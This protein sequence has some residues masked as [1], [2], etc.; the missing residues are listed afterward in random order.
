[1]YGFNPLD[2]SVATQDPDDDGL[3]N[4]QEYQS[5]GNPRQP[6][7]VAWGDN[8]TQES[9]VPWGFPAVPA[10]AAG[11]G[12]AAGGHTVLLMPD[13][14]VTAWGANTY[15]QT[16]VPLG[17]SN[18]VAVAAGGDQS[19]ALQ[20]NG[21]VVQWGRT[22]AAVPNYLS[23]VTAIAVGYQHKLAL[24]A[25]GTVVSW[26][27][28][29]CPANTV[30]GGLSN[31]VA[32]SAGWNHNLALRSDGTVVA[33]G[34][35]GQALGWNLTNVPPGLTGVA[36]ISAG[37]LH[38][39][40]LRNDGS[41]MAWGYNGGGE[42][43]VPANLPYTVAIAAGRGYTLAL[44]RDGTVSGW[45]A[46][47]PAFPGAMGQLTNL[48]AG[49]AHALAL[50]YGVLTPLIIGQPQSQAVLAGHDAAFTVSVCSRRQPAYQWQLNGTNIAGA[51]T[52]QHVVSG[53]QNSDLG[54][55]SVSVTNGAGWT[56]S[57]PAKLEIVLPPVMVS[58]L[59]PQV[60]W[61]PPGSNV[62]L[63]VT[64]TAQASDLAP[65]SY[66]WYLHG[67]RIPWALP[68]S[69]LTLGMFGPYPEGPY[70]VTVT[71]L[72]GSTNSAPW[73]V[74]FM[75][76]GT[77]VAWGDTGDGVANPPFGLSNVLAV[78]CGQ[79]HAVA[80][81]EG[82]AVVAWGNNDWGQTN[83]PADAANVTAVACGSD[84]TLALRA[85]GT[86]IAWGDDSAA[87]RMCR[88]T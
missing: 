74:H 23:G 71:N 38:S 60:V 51:T 72:A 52:S 22:F 57:I 41:V 63:S 80:L 10:M 24:R 56:S 16:N 55:Y 14:T 1:L 28:S 39:V 70:S 87:R 45:G 53:V 3:T 42:T 13:G 85:D 4:L 65:L 86:I 58:P 44:A 43:N 25:D 17:L 69:N 54:S 62:V 8:L 84:H 12:G 82:G 40:A 47:L 36:A 2:P 83:V 21:T 81:L 7:L 30:P 15:G 76:P 32:I 18:A 29:N 73:I 64:A 37:A 88:Q 34:L 61:A 78:A 46:G 48:V 50:R 31:V 5:G 68:V 35:S 67:V 59:T 26:G 77:A 27:A 75:N 49:P 11:G 19:A 20:A 79:E 9:T 33:W 6:M 66:Y